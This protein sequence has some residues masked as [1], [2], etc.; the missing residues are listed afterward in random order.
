MFHFNTPGERLKIGGFLTFSERIEMEHRHEISNA[1]ET[2]LHNSFFITI[3]K[4]ALKNMSK[5]MFQKCVEA[6]AEAF[7]KLF[8]RLKIDFILFLMNC[9]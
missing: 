3:Q 5:K 7:I 8:V 4:K 6:P 1:P 9:K 2:V